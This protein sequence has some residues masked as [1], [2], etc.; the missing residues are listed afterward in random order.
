MSSLQFLLGAMHA[1]KAMNPLTE[2]FL[3]ELDI[4][5]EASGL[6]PL[7]SNS[8]STQPRRPSAVRN[9]CGPVKGDLDG[10]ISVLSFRSDEG[11][12]QASV[13][14][15]ESPPILADEAANAGRQMNF[16]R[17]SP[18]HGQAYTNLADRRKDSPLSLV[19]EPAFG[20]VSYTYED[21]SYIVDMEPS[22]ENSINQRYASQSSSGQPTPSISSNNNSS[23]T[24]FNPLSPD[25]HSK[26]SNMPP[27]TGLSPNI[28]TSATAFGNS[29]EFSTFDQTNLVNAT[30]PNGMSSPFAIP[31]SWS[32][33]DI[34]QSSA[35]PAGKVE[36]NGARA[37]EVPSWQ[38]I[39]VMEGNEG[40]F[41]N[42]N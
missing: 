1:M 4:E 5:M 29:P 25:D 34:R 27:A 39:N 32:H 19:P 41:S 3:V 11:R 23:H 7:F 24:S 21:T 15:L 17:T 36:L 40:L 22:F 38:S 13:V 30:V 2:S 31:S 12:Q 33:A 8:E 10:C 26:F 37:A 35:N 9:L 42:W 18:T 6:T 28:A 20:G 14:N 16:S